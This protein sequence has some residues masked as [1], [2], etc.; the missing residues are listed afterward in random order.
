MGAPSNFCRAGA[1]GQVLY[2]GGANSS[3]VSVTTTAGPTSHM[4]LTVHQDGVVRLTLQNADIG[5]PGSY[6]FPFSLIAGTNS[7]IT[8][9]GIVSG[10]PTNWWVESDDSNPLGAY[11]GVFAN[12]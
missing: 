7:V 2:T 3:R 6:V 8:L 1:H 4:G 10:S 11:S 9:D 12:A 5:T